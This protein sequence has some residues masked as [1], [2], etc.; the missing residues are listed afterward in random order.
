VSGL[1]TLDCMRRA[2][3][4][5]TLAAIALLPAACAST[6]APGAPLAPAGRPALDFGRDTFAFENESRSKNPDKPDLFA[7]Y[8]FVMARAVIQFKRFARFEPAAPRL[9]A[10]GYAAR[11]REVVAR[12]PWRD[13]LPDARRVVIPGFAS[14]HE[15]S[16]AEPAAVKEGLGSRLWTLLH[17]TNWRVVFPVPGAHQEQVAREVLA[18][19][20]AGEPAQLLVTNLP[21]WELNHTVI[22]Y[23]AWT[24]PDGAVEFAVYDPNDSRGP[25]VIAFDPRRRRFDARR[26]FDTLPGA[27]R[28]FR[29]YHGPFL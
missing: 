17:W 12:A 19:L 10:A 21:S 3:A 20:R 28:A 25:G 15:L 8:C 24:A 1:A 4:G 14:L 5:L 9:D 26:L 18:A 7:N 11:V 13:P 22:A 23:D 27:I 6:A 2:T 16:W 29:M